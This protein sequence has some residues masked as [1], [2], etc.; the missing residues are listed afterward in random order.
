[1]GRAITVAFHHG[2]LIERPDGEVVSLRESSVTSL[3]AHGLL[4]AS[5]V[6]AAHRFRNAWEALDEDRRRHDSPFER[7][8]GTGLRDATSE[9]QRVA[10]AK[11]VLRRCRTLLGVHGFDL[12]ARI[13]GDGYN[14]RDLCKTRRERDTATDMLRLHLTSVAAIF[15]S[16]G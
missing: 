13:C 1:M 10:E 15:A 12:V 8:G 7:L 2:A 16:A 9:G 5:Q 6:A 11:K 14:I 4:N 3:A